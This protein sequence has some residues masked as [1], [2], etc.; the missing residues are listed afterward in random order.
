MFSWEALSPST[1]PGS[2][3]SSSPVCTSSAAVGGFPGRPAGPGSGLA[4][5]VPGLLSLWALW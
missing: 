4:G 3:S 5:D 2:R 1:T